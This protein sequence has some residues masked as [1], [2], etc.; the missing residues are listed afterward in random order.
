ME[1]VQLESDLDLEGHRP[2]YR[3]IS[4]GCI[5]AGDSDSRRWALAKC[6]DNVEVWLLWWFEI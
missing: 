5:T 6:G 1:K 4:G 3:I 2:S